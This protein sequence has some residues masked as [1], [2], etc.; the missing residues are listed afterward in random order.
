MALPK[1]RSS[2]PARTYLTQRFD[3]TDPV[4][5]GLLRSSDNDVMLGA[6]GTIHIPARN[7]QPVQAGKTYT[8]E[9]LPQ[10]KEEAAT[11]SVKNIQKPGAAFEREKADA[12]RNARVRARNAAE[13]KK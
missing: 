2:N 6:K 4:H 11:K 7:G 9:D 13:G 12:A 10:L 5:V 3:K 8:K 1:D